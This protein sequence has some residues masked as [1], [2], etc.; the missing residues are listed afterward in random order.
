METYYKANDWK[1]IGKMIIV[2][3]NTLVE[4]IVSDAPGILIYKRKLT[5]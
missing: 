3:N 5:N 4:D 2:D 1:S